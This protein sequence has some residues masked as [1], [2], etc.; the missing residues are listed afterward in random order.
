MHHIDC[1]HSLSHSMQA[2]TSQLSRKRILD[3][4]Y[5]KTL[6]L[7]ANVPIHGSI[8]AMRNSSMMEHGCRRPA[9][10]A[11]SNGCTHTSAE[12][13]KHLRYISGFH[14]ILQITVLVE[15]VSQLV[16]GRFMACR[17]L[18][19]CVFKPSSL[20]RHLLLMLDTLTLVRLLTLQWLVLL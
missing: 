17:G 18:V 2:A 1:S 15:H 9:P 11:L 4:M 19:V 5:A 8:Y 14:M 13:D 20:M 6:V 10:V 7:G 3:A 16:H 12:P